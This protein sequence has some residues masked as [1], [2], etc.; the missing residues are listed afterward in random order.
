MTKFEVFRNIA[1]AKGVA[2]S[3][4]K[5]RAIHLDMNMIEASLDSAITS[6]VDE[7]IKVRLQQL[8]TNGTDAQKADFVMGNGKYY[9]PEDIEMLAKRSR[10]TNGKVEADDY[11]FEVC[12]V[13]G[14][15]LCRCLGN[16]DQECRDMWREICR[17][18]C[19]PS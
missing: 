4:N 6:A 17:I 2:I 12:H 15:V 7:E 14:Y 9:F 19:N 5:P 1:D 3:F 10:E 8:R 13:T 11:C 18:Q 16:G